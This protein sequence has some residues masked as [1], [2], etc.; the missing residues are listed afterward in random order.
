MADDSLF[1]WPQVPL[2]LADRVRL[3]QSGDQEGDEVREREARWRSE[4]EG[5]Q[6]G[7]PRRRRSRRRRRLSLHAVV[8]LYRIF[9]AFF[10]SLF[11]AASGA[12]SLLMLLLPLLCMLQA[13]CVLAP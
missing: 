1:P 5:V 7:V 3:A 13:E 11:L 9:P 2:I 12:R 4:K 10:L 8:M 6:K